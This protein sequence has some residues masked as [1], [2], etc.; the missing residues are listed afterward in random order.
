MIEQSTVEAAV[1]ECSQALDETVENVFNIIGAFDIPRYTYNSERKKFLPLSMSNIPV[2]NL[3]G[4]A[5]DKAELYRERYAIL[6]QRTHRHE[7][8]T[9]S[10]VV[11]HPDDSRSKFQLKTV[12]TLLGNTTKVGE[13]IVLGMITQLKEGKFFLEDPTGVVQLDLSKAQFHS[14]L[15]TESCFVLAEGKAEYFS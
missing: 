15:Y 7:L 1:Q 11:I 3:F 2:P 13:V 10:A 5:R 14:G 6:Q 12:E 8:F 4:T 9:P